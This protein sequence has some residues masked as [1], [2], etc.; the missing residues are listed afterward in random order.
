[1]VL[2][3]FSNIHVKGREG[4]SDR[5]H[6]LMPVLNT[7]LP[8]GLKIVI[9]SF[10]Q[11]DRR[12]SRT[13]TYPSLSESN[14]FFSYFQAAF[15]SIAV[16]NSTSLLSLQPLFSKQDS[17]LKHNRENTAFLMILV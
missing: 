4:G 7:P 5:S 14:P 9:S 13:L 2:S 10:S 8:S 3:W 12:E 17:R 15:V 1:M 16:F 11:S 6:F